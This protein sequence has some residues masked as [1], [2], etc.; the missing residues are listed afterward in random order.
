[1]HQDSTSQPDASVEFGAQEEP[2]DF[3]VGQLKTIRNLKSMPEYNGRVGKLVEYNKE[4]VADSLPYIAP[5][6]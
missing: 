5:A 3:R 1:M 6:Y 4:E 2:S